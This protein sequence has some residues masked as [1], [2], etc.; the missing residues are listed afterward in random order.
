LLWAATLRIQD[1]EATVAMGLERAH[2]E[3]LGQEEGLLVGGCGLL[4]CRGIPMRVEI[5]KEPV[6]PGLMS[7][8]LMRAGEFEG[9]PCQLIIVALHG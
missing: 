5:S 7:P 9:T 3:C 8:F 1:A 4:D 2:P 6:D